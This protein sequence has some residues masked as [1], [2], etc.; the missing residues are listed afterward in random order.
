[1]SDSEGKSDSEGESDSD[2]D[3]D[4]DSKFDGNTDSGNIPHSEDRH[5]FEGCT[6]GVLAFH[7]VPPSEE[8]YEQVQR[9]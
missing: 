4:D 8:D 5:A 9:P 6:F 7:I 2:L 1:M 3:S